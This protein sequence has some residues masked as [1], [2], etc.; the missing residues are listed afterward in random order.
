MSVVVGVVSQ[1][2]GCGKST[3]ARALAAAAAAARLK[4]H[5]ADLDPQQQTVLLWQK[6]RKDNRITPHL[7]V[8]GYTAAKDALATAKDDDIIIIDGPARSDS[9]TLKIARVAH[10]IVQ[11]SGPGLDD[12]HP[13]VM[14]FHE[15][16]KAGIPEE[17]MVM[18]LNHIL[19]AGEEE[20]ARRY[21]EAA[22]YRALEGSIPEKIGYRD[23]HDRGAAATETKHKSL[24]ERADQLMGAL[25]REVRENLKR[26]A[27]R[28]AK[29]AEA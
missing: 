26:E 7:T 22:G 12:L 20:H 29:K 4:V 1:K 21:V 23:A 15:L 17:R 2:G 24:N 18:A 27:T 6:A 5:L 19:S 13:A 14:L 8:R 11:P 25:L 9:D 3:I 28:T 10:L 16:V